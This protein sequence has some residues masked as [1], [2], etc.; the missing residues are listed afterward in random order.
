[1]LKT[2]YTETNAFFIFTRNTPSVVESSVVDSRD[3]PKREFL[4]NGRGKR[5]LVL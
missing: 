2:H 5:E 1:M 4:S 3:T